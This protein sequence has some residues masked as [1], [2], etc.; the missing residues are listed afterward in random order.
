MKNNQVYLDPDNVETS[1][2]QLERFYRLDQKTLQLLRRIVQRYPRGV[3]VYVDEASAQS[4]FLSPLDDLFTF[5]AETGELVLFSAD[6]HTFINA[7]IEM[8]MYTVGFETMLDSDDHWKVEF[9]IG[10]WKPIRDQLKRQLDI[11]VHSDR[12]I[13]VGHP[14]DPEDALPEDPYPFKTLV[15]T[16]NII[17]FTQMIRYAG[18]EDVKVHF[19]PGTDPQVIDTY[20][21]MRSAMKSVAAMLTIDD[22]DE[23]NQRL[24]FRLH[25]LEEQFR[26]A[27][28]PMPKGWEFLEDDRE[29]ASDSSSDESSNPSNILIGPDNS[30]ESPFGQLPPPTTWGKNRKKNPTSQREVDQ[31]LEQGPFGR[32]IDN[33][34]DD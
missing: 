23:F 26:P 17:A 32:F 3:I 14:P 22:V 21:T 33:L 5:N 13:E 10:A 18:R 9:A 2:R 15:S 11:P 12:L 4:M 20:Y 25:Q 24:V 27:S 31:K 8:W 7:L 30:D 29:A 1:M 6:S 16:F 28:L 19:P 34:F